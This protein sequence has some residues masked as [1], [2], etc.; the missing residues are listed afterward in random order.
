MS[1]VCILR[2]YFI[3]LLFY[4]FYLFRDNIVVAVPGSRVGSVLKKIMSGENVENLVL[5]CTFF[6]FFFFFE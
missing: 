3:H 2:N 6:V 5:I 1:Y 4:L